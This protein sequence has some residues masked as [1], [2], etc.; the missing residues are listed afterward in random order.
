MRVYGYATMSLLFTPIEAQLTDYSLTRY[1]PSSSNKERLRK[2]I[3][4]HHELGKLLSH[5]DH[6]ISTSCF[7]DG[8]VLGETFLLAF[9]LISE[10]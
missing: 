8:K 2:E 6:T 9:T 1:I 3:R 7:A 10:Q 4:Y 5:N